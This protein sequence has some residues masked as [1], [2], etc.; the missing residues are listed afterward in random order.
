MAFVNEKISEKD[1]EYF[2]SFNLKN[3]VTGDLLFSRKW[4]IDRKRDVFL[5]GMGGQGFYESEI[6]MYYALV[7]KKM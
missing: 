6:P 4:T 3:P 7:W 2:N 5:V 1:K